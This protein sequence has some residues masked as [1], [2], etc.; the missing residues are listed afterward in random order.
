MV[1]LV[2]SFHREMSARISVNGELLEEEILVEN[3]LRRRCTLVHILFNLYSSLVMERWTELVM[4]L[5]GGGNCM[6]C[7]FDGKLF[8]R[9]TRGCRQVQMNECQFA[10]GT[11]VLVTTRHGAEQALLNYIKV[12]RAFGMTVSLP[13]TKLI[14]TGYEI[15]SHV[16]FCT[17]AASQTSPTHLY[18]HLHR[19]Q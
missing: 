16:H 5:E 7:K 8:R 10:D 11:A 14:V 4:D 17:K 9:S 12:A 6:L 18:Q 19:K 15:S 3:G 2:R 13:K 1:K